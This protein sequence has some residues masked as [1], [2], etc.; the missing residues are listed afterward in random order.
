MTGRAAVAEAR[1]RITEST[2]KP[3]VARPHSEIDRDAARAD[4]TAKRR[5][6]KA[7]SAEQRQRLQKVHLLHCKELADW[8]IH[9]R[10]V[11]HAVNGQKRA[12]WQP[13]PPRIPWQKVALD[14]EFGI[15]LP[16]ERAKAWVETFGKQLRSAIRLGHLP[17]MPAWLVCAAE[18]MSPLAAAHAPR[19]L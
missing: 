18:L 5:R 9:R 2:Y 17:D 10:A 15:F 19:H 11:V 1:K 14:R 12:K 8:K 6:G 3:L 13:P 16:V 4:V 7:L